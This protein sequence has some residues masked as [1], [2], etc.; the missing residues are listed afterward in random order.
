MNADIK[1]RTPVP[2]LGEGWYLL[3]TD[4]GDF[5]YGDKLKSYDGR[6]GGSLYPGHTRHS[7]ATWVGAAPKCLAARYFGTT[8]EASLIREGQTITNEQGGKQSFIKAR[9]DAIPPIVLKLLAQCLGFGLR[10]YGKENW[11]QIPKEEHLAH[12]S[13]HINEWQLGDRS[14]PHLVNAMARLSFAL[15]WAVEDGDQAKEYVHPD[16]VVK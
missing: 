16:E 6:D 2:E 10:K 5:R 8:I 11:K 12:S 1:N 14:E 3:R 9:F 15:W 13:N 7:L 4:D